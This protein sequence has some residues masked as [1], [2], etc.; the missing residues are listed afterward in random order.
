MVANVKLDKSNDMSTLP[1]DD[2]VGGVFFVSD[3]AKQ[4]GTG[5]RLCICK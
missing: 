5:I 4:M 2:N 3:S 1:N